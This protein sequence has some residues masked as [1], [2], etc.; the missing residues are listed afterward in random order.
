MARQLIDLMAIPVCLEK[1]C[2]TTE[3]SGGK[4]CPLSKHMSSSAVCF[5]SAYCS[6]APQTQWHHYAT[7]LP[8]LNLRLSPADGRSDDQ[9]SGERIT[10]RQP[11]PKN[12]SVL[13]AVCRRGQQRTRWL[14]SITDSVDMNLHKHQEIVKDREAWHAAVHG[15]TKSWRWLSDRT[16]NVVKE[17][18][19]ELR[20]WGRQAGMD[21]LK[22]RGTF[23]TEGNNNNKSPT[24]ACRK[25]LKGW[26]GIA[27]SSTEGGPPGWNPRERGR[28]EVRRLVDD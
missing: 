18:G 14:D 15:V 9:V 16:T 28:G 5:L 26:I 24:H 2:L 23:H 22:C 17:A 13:R 25:V 21:V 6:S 19:W 4:R 20:S 7:S 1:G 11:W 12:N 8:S 3:S 10:N 27:S